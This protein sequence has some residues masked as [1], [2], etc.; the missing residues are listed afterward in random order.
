MKDCPNPHSHQISKTKWN[1][2]P[3][4]IL[5]VI[6]QCNGIRKYV[7]KCQE[8]HRSLGTPTKAIAAEMIRRGYEPVILRVNPPTDYN[9]CS[10]RDCPEPGIDMHHWAPRNVFGCWDCD[11]WPVSYLCKDHHREWHTRMDG[12]RRNAKRSEEIEAQDRANDSSDWEMGFI[13]SR[14]LASSPPELGTTALDPLYRLQT[15]R[16]TDELLL[17]DYELVSTVEAVDL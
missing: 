1:V 16:N 13:R 5:G 8:C 9:P 12:Y 7:L 3:S 4:N 10:Y 2:H 15:L 14:R 17:A 11:N 6:V